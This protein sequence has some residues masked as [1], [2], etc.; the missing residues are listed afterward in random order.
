MGIRANTGLSALKLL[1]L[2]FIAIGGTFL[3]VAVMI[4]LN[5]YGEELSVLTGI[6]AAVGAV[7]VLFGILLMWV[8]GK[9]KTGAQKLMARGEF[10]T[11]EIVDMVPD[12]SITVLGG[13]PMRFTVRC[14]ESDGT[15]HLLKSEPM[16]MQEDPGILGRQ[17]KVYV[18]NGSFRKYHVDM[19]S[20]LKN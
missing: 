7:L 17:G 20:L 2:I 1:S 4:R 3:A 11:G 12:Y 19:E 6:F 13:H 16:R 10:V 15:E 9:Q 8:A 5:L 18:K 14:L